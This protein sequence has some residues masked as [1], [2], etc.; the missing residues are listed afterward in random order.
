MR[1][2]RRIDG[3]TDRLGNGVCV[4]VCV[5]LLCVLCVWADGLMDGH[6]VQIGLG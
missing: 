5:F 1:V 6:I 3:R 2:L 4:C